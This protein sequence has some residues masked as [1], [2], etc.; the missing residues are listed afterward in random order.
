MVYRL[1]L[2]AGSCIQYQGPFACIIMG[3]SLTP[4]YKLSPQLEAL[5]KKWGGEAI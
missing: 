3:W 1:R 2:N 5:R 4:K